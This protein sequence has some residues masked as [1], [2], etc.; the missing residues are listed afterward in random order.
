MRVARRSLLIVRKIGADCLSR[1]KQ[2][3]FFFA[4]K[5]EVPNIIAAYEKSAPKD[6]EVLSVAVWDKPKDTKAAAK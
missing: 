3:A 5:R 6:L 1:D 4:G 2:S